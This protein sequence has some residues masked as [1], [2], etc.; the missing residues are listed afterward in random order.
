M[1]TYELFSNALSLSANSLSYSISERLADL[2]PDRA[3][4]EGAL[5]YCDVEA[6]AAS[7]LCELEFESGVHNQLCATWDPED[8]VER[9]ARNVWYKVHWK[10]SVLDCLILTWNTGWHDQRYL[11][12]VA[13]EMTIAE[14]FFA[15]VS[16]WNAEVRDE[17]LIFD[18]GYWQKS[19]TLFQAIRSSTFENLVLA[20]SLANDLREDL[21][22][23]FTTSDVYDRY[24]VPWKR[25]V[26][27]VGPPG[28]GKTRAVKALV[29]VLGKPCLYVKSF[30]VDHATEHDCIRQVFERARKTAPCVLVLEDLDSLITDGNRSFFLNELD[31][32]A[33]NRG[34]LTLA[35]SNH[36]GKLDPA[37][38][39]RPSRFDRKYHFELPGPTERS[40]YLRRWCASLVESA[41]LSDAGH[42]TLVDATDGFSFAY[43]EELTLSA[44]MRWMSTP[45]E[46][47]DAVSR[48]ESDSLRAQM[49]SE[50]VQKPSGTVG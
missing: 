33:A 23:F 1:N 11:W 38:V 6:Y 26:L 22:R 27:L 49:K 15:E 39:E 37:I 9:S 45:G 50:S 21:E 43:L 18:G 10:E 5:C 8:G 17:I 2:F 47:M 16:A 7:G 46:A 19:D 30:Q 28:N 31:G 20:G 48:R 40:T 4:L 44:M 32:F 35:S 24:K 3:I 34:I 29:N 25:G 36:P 42:E 41:K 14:S 13:D 12:V